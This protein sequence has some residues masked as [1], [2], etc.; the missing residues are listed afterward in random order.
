M[1]CS[2]VFC[3]PSSRLSICHMLC[4]TRAL[5][6]SLRTGQPGALACSGVPDST[7]SRARRAPGQRG[8]CR[9]EQHMVQAAGCSAGG[10]P[11]TFADRREGRSRIIQRVGRCQVLYRKRDV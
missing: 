6:R 3:A 11:H 7:D 10:A 8:S 2:V 5:L 1:G 4:A 9:G